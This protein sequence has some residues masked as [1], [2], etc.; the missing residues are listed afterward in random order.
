MGLGSRVAVAVVQAS[1]CSSDSTPSLGTSICHKFVHNMEKKKELIQ[2]FIVLM[3]ES[4]HGV[5]RPC[6]LGT[7]RKAHR[8]PLRMDKH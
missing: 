2:E 6:S 8:M 4:L 7:L 5:Q 3:K 1:S